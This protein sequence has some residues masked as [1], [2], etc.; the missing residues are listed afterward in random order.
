[1]DWS[2][3]QVIE[4][5]HL[6]FLAALRASAAD[7]RYVLKGGVNLRFFFH[8][9]RSSEDIDFDLH[10]SAVDSIERQA[11]RALVRTS[12]VLRSTGIAIV[13]DEITKPKQTRTTKRWKVPLAAPGFDDPVRTKV[14]F[15]ARSIDARYELSTVI[16]EITR[17]YAMVAPL[18]NHYLHPAATAQKVLALAYR[19]ETQ[20]RDVFDLNTLF[21]QAAWNGDEI[22]RNDRELA[23][24]QATALTFE[25]FRDQVVPFLDSSA[26]ALYDEP[27]WNQIQSSV[28]EKLLE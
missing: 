13:A 15:S 8:S 20:A 3:P 6:A 22:S 1:M 11:D 24:E 2:A 7:S 21:R 17:P 5:F 9:D 19:N 4:C 25:N 14:E 12:F 10:P 16:N 28:V 27:A 23:A 26:V 18:A